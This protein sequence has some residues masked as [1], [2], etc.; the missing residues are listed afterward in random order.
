MLSVTA[1]RDRRRKPDKY[2]LPLQITYVHSVDCVIL[3]RVDQYQHKQNENDVN[4]ILS[5]NIKYIIL[6]VA[7]NELENVSPI[8]IAYHCK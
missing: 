8:N 4:V 5:K 6:S 7:A 2:Y 3:Q 1:K